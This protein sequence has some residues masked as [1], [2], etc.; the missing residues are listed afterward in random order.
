VS[1]VPLNPAP[2]TA[3][4]V[5]DDTPRVGGRYPDPCGTTLS[6]ISTFSSASWSRYDA[7]FLIVFGC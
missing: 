4:V 6:S 1:K 3:I 7:R 5:I 2:I